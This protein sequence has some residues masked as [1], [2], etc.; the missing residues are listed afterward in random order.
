MRKC[1]TLEK[2]REKYS[3]Q[4]SHTKA[5]SPL[6]NQTALAEPQL[7][8][9]PLNFPQNSSVIPQASCCQMQNESQGDDLSAELWFQTGVFLQKQQNSH[10]Q[11]LI[12]R[13]VHV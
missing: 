3:R 5:C 12:N 2:N 4:E 9:M 11:P 1:K 6:H 8:S 7:L 13:T 10:F